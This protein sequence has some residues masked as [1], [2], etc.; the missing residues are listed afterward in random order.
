ML[1]IKGL[2]IFSQDNIIIDVKELSIQAG[3]TVA[4]VGKNNTGKTLLLKSMKYLYRNFDGEIFLKKNDI[5][6]TENSNII[7]IEPKEQLIPEHSLWKNITMVFPKI[8]KRTKKKL[9]KML[10]S[11]SL[12]EKVDTKVNILSSSEKKMVEIVRSVLQL[13]YLIL[14]DDMDKYFDR[15][16]LVKVVDIFRFALSSGT[17]IIVSSK[18]RFPFFDKNYRIN[19]GKIF[20]I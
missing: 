20:Q 14:I 13:P 10:K 16:Q 15:E 5:R 12:E 7:F 11:L 2:K 3:E 18:E 9:E 1:K 4:F 6:D 8:S 19:K 17:S